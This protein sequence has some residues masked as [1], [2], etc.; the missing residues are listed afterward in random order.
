MDL[1]RFVGL[2]PFTEQPLAL[3][4]GIVSA[5]GAFVILPSERKW[6]WAAA[7][8]AL[9]SFFL[10]AWIAWRYQSFTL[11][12]LLRPTNIVVLTAIVSLLILILVWRIVGPAIG[13]ILVIFGALALGGST[14]G[15]PSTPAD[16][17][18]LYL[19]LDPNSLLGLPL[20]VALEIVIP[21]VLFGRILQGCGGGDWF[22]EVAQAAFGR[23]RG[24]AA[25]VSTCA[26]ALLGSVS[27]NAVSNVIGTGVVTI[28]MMKRT[29]FRGEVAAAVEAVA[30]TGGQ[31]LPPIMGSA[32]F[33]M[34]DYLRVPYASIAMAALLPS[35][36]YYISVFIMV[37]RIAV[38]DGI[39][40]VKS[41]AA[42][43][44]SRFV[45]G[46]HFTLPFI[47]VI[48]AF[49]KLQ[50]RPEI[51]ALGAIA[52]L[53]VV[54]ALRPYKGQRLTLGELVDALKDAGVSSMPVLITC[55][56]A[57]L[58]IGLLNI[59]GLGFFLASNAIGLS[60][61]SLSLLLIIVAATA[62]IFGLGMPTVAVYILLATLLGPALVDLGLGP[63][64][65]HLFIF[66]FG[67]LSMLTPPIALA[68]LAA[69]NLAGADM[70]KAS[71]EAVKLG[72]VAYIIPFL[73][74]VS[75]SLILEGHWTTILGTALS[76]VVGL[77]A[78]AIAAVGYTEHRL[79]ILERI[80]WGAAGVLFFIPLDLASW[81]TMANFIGVAMF[82]ALILVDRVRRRKPS[83]TTAV[84]AP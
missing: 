75:P 28:P 50:T 51:A 8:L 82:V 14:I 12:A 60:G 9:L 32:A 21:F 68:V 10:F 47:V 57:G 46:A 45:E 64:Q 43:A 17:L 26:S 30:S 70:W 15:L 22:T 41:T 40:G 63:I 56:A 80:L 11:V 31:M 27:G 3:A 33:V 29:G 84:G 62:I 4:L 6:R 73:F 36:L 44:W 72:W 48:F 53:I 5:M 18:A 74:I 24:G 23:F 37:D 77:Y 20:R 69:A 59:T 55:A 39:A 7:V 1:H 81:A 35:L 76:A 78:V 71:W 52:S 65:A 54:S 16:R 2:L 19:A 13:V 67:M 61:G 25:K 42:D 66:Y 58:L 34:A 38:R 49:L 83:P 79:G